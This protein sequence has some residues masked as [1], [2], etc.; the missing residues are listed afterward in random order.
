MTVIWPDGTL[1]VLPEKFPKGV[2]ELIDLGVLLNR[3]SKE[4]LDE[5]DELEET[6]KNRI[7]AIDRN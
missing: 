7:L 4:E 3:L 6:L 2:Q 1:E 5:L